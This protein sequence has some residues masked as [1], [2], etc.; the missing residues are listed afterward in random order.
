M[1]KVAGPMPGARPGKCWEHCN[2]ERA[3][4]EGVLGRNLQRE[5]E[6]REGSTSWC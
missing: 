1:V 6:G 5:G 3:N 4:S 2:D